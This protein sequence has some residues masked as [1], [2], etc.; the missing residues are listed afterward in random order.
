VA[1]PEIAPA[2]DAQAANRL[3]GQELQPGID[4]ARGQQAPQALAGIAHPEAAIEILGQGER[5]QAE[6]RPP[7]R[8]AAHRAEA[9]GDRFTHPQAMALQAH[10]QAAIAGGQQRLHEG[11]RQAGP[12]PALR[13]QAQT[14][15]GQQAIGGT[16]PEPALGILGEC[17]DDA[18]RHR[19]RIGQG[20]DR[21]RRTDEGGKARAGQ[22][23]GQGG[24]EPAPA[25]KH[26][27]PPRPRDRSS[28]IPRSPRLPWRPRDHGRARAPPQ[29]GEVKPRQTPRT[30]RRRDRA[31]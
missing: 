24:R 23:A 11:A 13:A 31:G 14:I 25:P 22:Q 4:L 28:G 27:S 1:Q 26:L 15:E 18:V 6:A 17:G 29:H 8:I 10:P 21:R 30:L 20:L 2:V 9:A 7:G 3:P 16:H 12:G 5:G 19:P